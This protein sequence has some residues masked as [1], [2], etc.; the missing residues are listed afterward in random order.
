MIEYVS[1]G[2]L[3]WPQHTPQ[4]RIGVVFDQMIWGHRFTADQTPW[5][6]FLETLGL[7][8]ARFQDPAKPTLFATHQ[9]GVH[10]SFEYRQKYR[11]TLR[12]LLF[13]DSEADKLA[14]VASASADT[15]VWQTWRDRAKDSASA[16]RI[17]DLTYLE[18]RFPRFST[19]HGALDLLRSAEI[20]AERDRRP[21]SRHL[22]PRGLDLLMADYD[23]KKNGGIDN[24]RRFFAR[25]GEIVY[26]MLA[27]SAGA[28][29][30]TLGPLIESRLLTTDSRWNRLA[31]LLE[32]DTPEPSGLDNK[33]GYLPVAK[34]GRYDRLAEDW[35]A[36]LERKN[37]PADQLADPLMRLTGLHVFLYV[38]ERAKE[39]QPRG[40][41]LAIPIDM[42]PQV[43][44]A[45]RRQSM[46]RFQLHR[47]ITRLALSHTIDEFE[48]GEIW[49]SVGSAA[50]PIAKAKKT[51]ADWFGFDKASSTAAS[52]PETVLA[53]MR[54]E[55]SRKHDNNMGRI[56]GFYAEQIGMTVGSGTRRWYGLSD[57]MIEA[58]VLANVAEPLEYEIFLEKLRDRYGLVIGNAAG[59]VLLGQDAPLEQLEQNQRLFEERLRVL[60]LLSRLSDDCAFVSNPFHS[61]SL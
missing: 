12:W 47:Q 55:A 52:S 6:T 18:Q 8:A 3:P 35:A 27:R 4:D 46:E 45:L 40:F 19:Y 32:P 22:A 56:A 49:A 37:L 44:G 42:S 41:T 26:L 54:K 2:G 15:S 21:T 9:D 29:D 25:G 28:A 43:P 30:G 61:E 48:Q 51:L 1:P 16:L 10:E 60:G 23:R 17:G 24:D 13:T 38:I 5:L 11:S 50:D 14:E 57:G 7:L 31:Q 58:L 53:E 36:V 34:H 39:M 20:E 33:I 59:S